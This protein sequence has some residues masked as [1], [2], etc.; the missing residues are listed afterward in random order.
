MKRIL[1]KIIGG[2]AEVGED[3]RS[4]ASD[5]DSF[6]SLDTEQSEDLESDDG[7]SDAMQEE[8]LEQT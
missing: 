4:H 6:Y 2:E 1:D 3:H 8:D 7:S 5:V